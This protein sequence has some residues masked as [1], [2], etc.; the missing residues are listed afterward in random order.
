M[1]APD[2]RLPAA[3]LALVVLG[4]CLATD[5][6]LSTASLTLPLL[7]SS[8]VSAAVAAWGVPRLRRLKLGQVIR[9]EGPQAHHSKAGKIGRAHV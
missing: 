5:W 1:T 2:G 3:L 7:V 4:T 9:D 6:S 8:A